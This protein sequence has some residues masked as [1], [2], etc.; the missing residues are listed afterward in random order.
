MENSPPGSSRFGTLLPKRPA[1]RT[2][3]ALKSPH[4]KRECGT[5]SAVLFVIGRVARRNQGKKLDAK[6][7]E[8]GNT[9][10][11]EKKNSKATCNGAQGATE[12]VIFDLG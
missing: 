11:A 2:C 1:A 6:N 12:E 7:T 3:F 9:E 10:G 8:I 4:R 5:A